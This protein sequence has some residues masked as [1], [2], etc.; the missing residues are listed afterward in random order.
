[1]PVVVAVVQML[2]IRAAQAGLVAAEPEQGVTTTV[3]AGQPTL[4]VVAVDLNEQATHQAQVA[5]AS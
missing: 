1:L 2:L 4:A 3:L 5:P